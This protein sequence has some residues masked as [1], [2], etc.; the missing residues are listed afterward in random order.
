MNSTTIYVN[1]NIDSIFA[2]AALAVALGRKGYRVF[3]EFPQES[4]LKK[5]NIH[6]SYAVDILHTS[7]ASLRNSIALSHLSQRKL[8]LIYKYDT[9]GKYNI[10]MKLSNV[11]STLEIALEYIKTLNESVSVPGNL[12]NDLAF[13]K[14]NNVKRL[15]R[16][17][18]VLYYAYRWGLNNDDLLHTIY[19]YAYG[20]VTTKTLKL[21]ESLEKAARNFEYSLNIKD[22]IINEQRYMQKD[23]VALAIISSASEDEFVRSNLIY[24][25][26]IINE[27]LSD[28]CR[29]HALAVLVYESNQVHEAK[30]CI[31]R[32]V[33]IDLSKMFASLPGDILSYVNYTYK[34]AQATMTFKNPNNATLDNAI[35]ICNAVIS[36][37]IQAIKGV[38][39]N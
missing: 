17:G 8:G 30:F 19:N 5:L 39:N 34:G 16:I 1:R 21:S 29:K 38:R 20:V 32:D 10:Y 13:I 7:G 6:N 24:I 35:R 2:A 26:S 37:F 27:L 4:S 18:R 22:E 28:L 3:I 25:K 33:P 9:E 36:E 14:S 15:T 23:N 31:N 11:S 12:L